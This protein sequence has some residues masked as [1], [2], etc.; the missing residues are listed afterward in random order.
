[1]FVREKI[2]VE[3]MTALARQRFNGILLPLT[4]IFRIFPPEND[5]NEM[6]SQMCFSCST[7]RKERTTTASV[8]YR[9]IPVQLFFCYNNYS[10]CEIHSAIVNN[11]ESVASH[12]SICFEI[13][14]HTRIKWQLT[15]GS[16][17]C[18]YT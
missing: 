10:M 18:I 16:M 15:C 17:L 9:E 11:N 6:I 4:L 2:F 13:W 12:S 8:I 1:M 14:N 5:S 3:L 7:V